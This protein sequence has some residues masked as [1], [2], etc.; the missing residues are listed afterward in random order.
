MKYIKYLV[1]LVFILVVIFF[2]LKLYSGHRSSD[3][4]LRLSVDNSIKTFDP[5]VVFN[6][7]GLTVLSQSLETL[8]QYHYLKRPYEVIPSLAE[9]MPE[10]TDEGRRYLIK[11]KRGVLYHPHKFLKDTREVIAD[12]FIWAIKRLAFRPLKST[13]NWLF[14]GKIKGFNNFTNEVGDSLEK[15]YTK[16]IEGLRKIDDYTFEILL[17]KPEP[18]LLYFLSMNFTSPTPIELLKGLEND[19]S[20]TLVGTGAFYLEFS[21]DQEY[22]FKKFEKFHDE[23]YPTV[24]DRYANTEQLLGSSREKLPFL[25]GVEFKVIENENERWESFK[26][27]EIDL[28]N[29]PKKFLSF[30]SQDESTLSQELEEMGVEVKHFSRQTS[31]WLGFNMND[32]LVGQNDN[33]RKALAH[34]VD[35]DEYIKIVTNNTSL[36]ANSI[37]NPSIPGYRPATKLDYEYNKEKALRYLHASKV[38]PS[39]VSLT[40]STRGKEDVHFKETNFFKSQFAKLGIELKIE[41]L[42]FSQFLKRGRAG[43]LQVWTDNWIYDYPDGENILQLLVSK[44]HPGINKSGYSDNEV[45]KLFL[46]MSTELDKKER[47]E[48]MYDIEKIVS[49]DTPWVMLLYESTYIL[50]QKNVKNFRKSF[51]IRNYTKYIRKD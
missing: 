13:G 11:I 10:I 40:Y 45:D 33:F 42:N 7:D 37:Y 38:N 46:R 51:F 30:L 28:L 34:I 27:K 18:N 31:R 21:N 23:Y 6:D 26:N 29:L 14:E 47:F 49:R 5:A 39:A 19:L 2:L 35:V 8:Y 22:R 32:P 36:K 25:S 3:N 48:L 16:E 41:T 20:E 50:K 12:D 15:F 17:E 9:S 43:E 4:I 1:L 24:G 44:N